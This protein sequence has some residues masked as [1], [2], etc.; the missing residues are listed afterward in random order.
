MYHPAAALH[1]GALRGEIAR[2]F[3]FL[4]DRIGAPEGA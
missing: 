2:D 3:E 4:H 1:N